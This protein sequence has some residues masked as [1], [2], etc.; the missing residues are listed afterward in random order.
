[1]PVPLL[2]TTKLNSLETSPN[3][4]HLE[5][6]VSEE[7][8][9][10][11]DSYIRYWAEHFPA[12]LAQWTM[13]TRSLWSLRE[14][15]HRLSFRPATWTRY[16]W[17]YIGFWRTTDL[18]GGNHKHV[19]AV[20]LA[21]TLGVHIPPFPSASCPQ[22]SSD[23]VTVL[24]VQKTHTPHGNRQE[25]EQERVSRRRVLSRPIRSL[26]SSHRYL[27]TP[28]YQSRLAKTCHILHKFVN[29]CWVLFTRWKNSFAFHHGNPWRH[30]ERDKK[31]S[32]FH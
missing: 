16:P 15:I 28:N 13:I 32:L 8:D 11:R 17:E 20:Y 25:M 23:R 29:T 19:V 7:W 1:M 22:Q 27:S 2:D 14:E 26:P 4:T 18:L 6:M 5:K 3:V 24:E 21:S 31:E 30:M 10:R 9:E 12:S